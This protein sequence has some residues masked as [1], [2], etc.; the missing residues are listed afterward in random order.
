M[1]EFYSVS[2]SL[3][4]ARH[5]QSTRANFICCW[6]STWE[7]V[8]VYVCDA[9]EADARSV[10]IRVH[11]SDSQA[12]KGR[13]RLLTTLYRTP[14]VLSRPGSPR[15]RPD[16]D[17]TGRDRDQDHTGRP[18]PRP[19]PAWSRPRP[20]PETKTNTRDRDR[21]ICCLG[22]DQHTQTVFIHRHLNIILQ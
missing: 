5:T 14:E 19:R 11:H 18:R 6:C 9:I 22:H 21:D 2:R 1:C 15:P 20:T 13:L 7:T 3:T 8:R 10:N 12:T 16:Q 17:Q 4:R